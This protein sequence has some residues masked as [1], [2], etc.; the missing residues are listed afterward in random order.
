MCFGQEALHQE[1]ELKEQDV[2][3]ECQHAIHGPD[4]LDASEKLEKT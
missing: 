2:P 1:V 3:A 4:G